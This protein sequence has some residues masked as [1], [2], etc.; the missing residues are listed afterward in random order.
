MLLFPGEEAYY[1]NLPGYRLLPTAQGTLLICSGQCDRADRPLSCRLFPLL[2]VVREGGVKVA[3]EGS[4][5]ACSIFSTE[6]RF[7]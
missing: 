3:M 6:A 5:L 1:A 2:P 4:S 7:R